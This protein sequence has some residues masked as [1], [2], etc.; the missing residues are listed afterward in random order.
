M[1]S[2]NSES[3]AAPSSTVVVVS[4]R[5]SATL[6]EGACGRFCASSLFPQ[7]F[8]RAIF[9][10]HPEFAPP[11]NVLLSLLGVFRY[12]QKYTN[13]TPGQIDVLQTRW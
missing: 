13:G 6:R 12:N 10:L 3:S 5:S 9:E 7:Y 4:S 1:A 11:N 2:R 8:E